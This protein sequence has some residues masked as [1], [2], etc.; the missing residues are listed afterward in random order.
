MPAVISTLLEL[1]GPPPEGG[2]DLLIFDLEGCDL[3]LY[4][5]ELHP[6][7]SKL[8]PDLRERFD[9]HCAHRKKGAFRYSQKLLTRK[10]IKTDRTWLVLKRKAELDEF[11]RTLPPNITVLGKTW[12]GVDDSTLVIGLRHF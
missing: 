5:T 9:Y 12:V 4:Y 3:W 8:G 6:V 10:K 1:Q 7:Y 2:P 11:P